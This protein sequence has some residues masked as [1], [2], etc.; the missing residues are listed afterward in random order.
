MFLPGCCVPNLP[1]SSSIGSKK[2]AQNPSAHM[3]NYCRGT[4]ANDG[5]N[6][7]SDALEREEV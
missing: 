7:V 5:M 4:S 6:E 1:K 3:R 2:S